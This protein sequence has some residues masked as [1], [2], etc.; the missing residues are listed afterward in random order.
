MKVTPVRKSWHVSALLSCCYIL[1]VFA[2]TAAGAGLSLLD[3]IQLSPANSRPV[4]S[5]FAMTY[6]P[7]S[8]K[9]IAFGGFD[10]TGYL[11]DTWSSTERLGRRSPRNLRLQPALPPK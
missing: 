10:G 6:D 3:W 7:I 2:S 11:N 9:L 8:G 5:Y 1:M 4:R